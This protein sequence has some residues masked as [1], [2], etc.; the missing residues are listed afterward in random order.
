[1]Q[2]LCTG[3]FFL[4]T[5]YCSHEKALE[6][7]NWVATN[8]ESKNTTQDAQKL[9]YP[10][11]IVTAGP[12]RTPPNPATSVRELEK[13]IRFP[14][15]VIVRQSIIVRAPLGVRFRKPGRPRVVEEGRVRLPF[16]VDRASAVLHAP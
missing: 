12:S 5:K 2:A 11:R 14:D 1:M 6:S 15:Q 7:E 10:G 16:E 8:H 13:R 3:L 4:L 9:P